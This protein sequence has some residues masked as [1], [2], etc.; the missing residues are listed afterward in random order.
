MTFLFLSGRFILGTLGSVTS[1]NVEGEEAFLYYNTKI[2]FYNTKDKC[3][4]KSLQTL[5]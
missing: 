2:H 5:V 3:G 1:K 4:I